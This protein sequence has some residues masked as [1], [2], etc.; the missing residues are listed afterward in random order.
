MAKQTA[1]PATVAGIRIS[2]PD[3]IIY[4]DLGLSKIQ[5]ARYYEK[6]ADWVVPHVA[7]RPLTLVH[8]PAGLASPCI[9]LKHAKA[10]GPSALRRVQIQ[11]KTKVGEYLVADSIEGVVSL[12][13][14]GIVE[15]HTWNSLIEDIERPNR[16]VWD[17]D[18]GPS[19]T[20]PQ[21]GK[22]AELV[23]EVLQTLGLKSWLKTTG[24]RGLHIVVPITPEWD[25]AKCLE[26]SRSVGEALVRTDP[27]LYTT[28]FAKL[29]RERKILIDYLR[30]NRTNTSIAAFSPRTR[31]GAPVSMPIDWDDLD[32]P[33]ERYTLITVPKRL[34]RARVDPWAGYWTAAQ[35]VSD[36]SFAAITNVAAVTRARSTTGVLLA[37]N[38]DQ[39][40]S[41]EVR[42]A[43]NGGAN[44]SETATLR[45][46]LVDEVKDLYN[47]EKQL[48]K[49]LPKLAKNATNPKL[50][51]ALTSHLRETENQVGRLEQVFG[52]LDEKPKGKL[53][54]GMQGIIEEANG[55]LEEVE[56][57]PVMDACI[58]GA[59]QKAEHYEMASYGTCIAWAEAL[60][61]DDVARLLQQTLA[62]E[63][64]ADEKLS[65][66]AEAGVNEAATV[67]SE[68]DDE[69]DE[70][71]SRSRSA[72]SARV[73]AKSASGRNGR[74]NGGR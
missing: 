1:D 9:Y 15:V 13:Q 59:G 8:C 50:R 60:G 61:L 47:A 34:N 32:T 29:G 25:V 73:A 4:P 33:P 41:R 10:W 66:I 3:R 38:A 40:A 14:M 74:R 71:P 44:M 17:L 5:L 21:V 6:I 26:F 68:D 57:G 36:A 67:G 58:I 22:A 49:A 65:A 2:H 63:K 28:T 27:R 35:Q 11:E 31:P 48:T 72:G 43:A 7:G 62:E 70:Q 64:A 16:I 20:W 12:A 53:C 51:D 54:D 45:E 23:R 18:P 30:N 56:E 46:A 42:R 52:L 39:D 24:G 69:E 19:V 55:M 37:K